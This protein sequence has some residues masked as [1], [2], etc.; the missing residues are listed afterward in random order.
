MPLNYPFLLL[1]V[2]NTNLFLQRK[3]MKKLSLYVFLVLMWCNVGFAEQDCKQVPYIT[4]E[5]FKRY[6]EVCGATLLCDS[7]A[8]RYA[9]KY[10]FD[11]KDQYMTKTED[12][13]VWGTYI[14]GTRTS[15][16]FSYGIYKDTQEI[17]DYFFF[18]MTS[19]LDN[20]FDI[21]SNTGDRWDFEKILRIL[22]RI[23]SNISTFDKFVTVPSPKDDYW[24]KRDDKKEKEKFAAIL[25]F[26]ST[27]H[28]REKIIKQ[29][30]HGI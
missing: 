20:H 10:T 28:N 15:G 13:N 18:V 27:L 26:I 30:C 16:I 6:K 2:M 11:F 22:S 23:D 29:K 17:N 3:K 14:V 8:R 12:Y 9:I 19:N 21:I 5:G 4:E 7:S 1:S 24:R 25:K